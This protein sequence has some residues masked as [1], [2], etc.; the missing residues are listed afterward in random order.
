MFPL[1]KPPK[2][3]P[4]RAN[5]MFEANPTIIIE[6]IV[7]I[8]PISKTGFRPTLSDRPPQYIPV[9]DSASAKAEMRRPA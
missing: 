6:T 7:P 4:N 2:A 3:L 9:R 8:H 5:Q 1:R